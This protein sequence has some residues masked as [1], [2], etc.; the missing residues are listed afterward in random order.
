M[1]RVFSPEV[2]TDRGEHWTFRTD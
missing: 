1:I 2:L